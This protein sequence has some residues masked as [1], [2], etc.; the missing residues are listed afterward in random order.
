MELI[1]Q[2]TVRHQGIERQVLL[3]LGDLA[4][5]RVRLSTCS[6]CPRFPMT[7]IRHVTV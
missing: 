2:I 5:R 7:T 1:D 6:S 4:C 3:F